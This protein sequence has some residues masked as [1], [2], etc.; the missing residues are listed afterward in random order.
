MSG[1]AGQ[2]TPRALSGWPCRIVAACLLVSLGSG[3]ARAA[4]LHAGSRLPS[5]VQT[6]GDR[7]PDALGGG[8]RLAPG[9]PAPS[10]RRKVILWDEALVE[11]HP[12]PPRGAFRAAAP[13]DGTSARRGGS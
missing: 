11:S 2:G 9:T 12:R 13:G 8:G 4:A 7:E 3:P 10:A 5:T 6:I 1:T